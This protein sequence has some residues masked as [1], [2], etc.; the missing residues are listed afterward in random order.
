M[1]HE[2]W[3]PEHTKHI[4][5]EKKEINQAIERF[6]PVISHWIRRAYSAGFNSTAATVN[7]GF[8]YFCKVNGIVDDNP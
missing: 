1:V 4:E 3:G 7:E 2:E 8:A 5:E 6:T